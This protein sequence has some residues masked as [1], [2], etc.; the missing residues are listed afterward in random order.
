VIF[1]LLQHIPNFGDLAEL[2]ANRSSI[3]CRARQDGHSVMQGPRE[4]RADDRRSVEGG[5]G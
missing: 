2:E 5:R 4:C 1:P 3:R